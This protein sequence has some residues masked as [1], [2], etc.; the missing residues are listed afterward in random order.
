MLG[1]QRV[2][3]L[4][5]IR[6][7]MFGFFLSVCVFVVVVVVDEETRCAPI[8]SGRSRKVDIVRFG[9]RWDGCLRSVETVR[10]KAWR[11]V[12]NRGAMVSF[13][14]QVISRNVM[15]KLSN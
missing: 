7:F 4:S 11:F 13:Y 12:F 1:G 10:L 5:R 2:L 3:S 8:C 6:A 9:R 14:F 15:Y